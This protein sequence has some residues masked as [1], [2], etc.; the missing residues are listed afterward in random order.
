MKLVQSKVATI[1]FAASSVKEVKLP[2]EGIV[3]RYD[4]IL[5]LNVTTDATEGGTP[6]EDALM[7]IIKWLRI[8]GPGAKTYFAVS[9][10]RLLKYRAIYDFGKFKE[11]DLPTAAGVTADVRAL[12]PIYFGINP[13]DRFDT[14]TVIPALRLSELV[15][16]VLWGAASDLGSGYT[17]NS[18]QLDIIQYALVPEEGEPLSRFFPSGIPATRMEATTIDI[19]ELKSDLGLKHDVPTGD[20]LYRSLI[21]ITDSADNRSDDEVSE[22]GVVVEK[23][24]FIPLRIP[25]K[26]LGDR[27]VVDYGLDS[28]IT[29]VAML[30]W[31]EVSGIPLGVD[32]SGL[33]E[34]DVKLGFT[35]VATGGKIYIMHEM[36]TVE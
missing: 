4:A 17:I 14:S 6:K 22:I 13:L 31:E 3:T 25:W 7:R 16:R 27:D 2:T 11:D 30:D 19:N 1:D 18:G 34:G 35:T 10:G 21:M 5:K 24:R 33:A 12:I 28:R 9:D 26:L 36:K 8:E 20:V 29:G 15:M 32:M 23:E